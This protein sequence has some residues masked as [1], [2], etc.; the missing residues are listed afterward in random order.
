MKP[1]AKLEASQRCVR[2]I[3]RKT[4]EYEHKNVNMTEHLQELQACSIHRLAD[5]QTDKKMHVIYYDV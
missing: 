1:K 2:V 4:K 3:N 5:G